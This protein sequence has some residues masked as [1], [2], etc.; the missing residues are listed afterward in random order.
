M[1]A[2]SSVLLHRLAA[3]HATEASRHL[4]R[5]KTPPVTDP[6][7]VADEPSNALWCRGTVAPCPPPSNAAPRP[8]S[9]APR[10]AA[11]G[12]RV[13][14]G[15]AGARDS[16]EGITGVR[17][18]PSLSMS[19]QRRGIKSVP[20]STLASPKNAASPSARKKG[21]KAVSRGTGKPTEEARSET[22]LGALLSRDVRS[23]D[24]SP[25]QSRHR[26][27]TPP[28]GAAGGASPRKHEKRSI[29]NATSTK[30]RSED[31]CEA[32]S[33]PVSSQES[34]EINITRGSVSSGSS[35]ATTVIPP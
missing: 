30:N 6:G 17:V 25:T 3:E 11:R 34:P 27:A 14:G 32:P 29:K 10:S 7:S 23:V 26:I 9:V 12:T 13:A 33:S 31:T 2:A 28:M 35:T 8:G 1:A 15:D 22:G 18:T 20:R 24:S 5:L 16:Q 4:K 19:A 21:G